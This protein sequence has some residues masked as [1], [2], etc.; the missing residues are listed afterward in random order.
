MASKG[1]S[2]ATIVISPDP[3][4]PT[5][6]T[7]AATKTPD[8]QSPGPSASLVKFKDTA[9]KAERDPDTLKPEAEGDIQKEY[10][11]DSCAAQ[12]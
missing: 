1:V 3:W 4:S 7:S 6:T 9:D 10:S 11:F 5:P 8:P 12:I 2:T